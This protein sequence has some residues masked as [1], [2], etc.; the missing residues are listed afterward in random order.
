MKIVRLTII[1]RTASMLAMD[2]A[3]KRLDVHVFHVHHAG[4]IF[5]GD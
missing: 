2:Q 3:V 1:E 4:I 5:Y